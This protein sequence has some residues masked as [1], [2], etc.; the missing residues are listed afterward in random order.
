MTPARRCQVI[1]SA[2]VADEF[3]LLVDDARAA[4]R[5]PAFAAAARWI[6]EGLARTP[7][8]FGESW[9][10]RPGSERIFRRGFVRPVQLRYAV[11][12]GQRAVSIRRFTLLR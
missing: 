12:D 5:L 2:A 6:M 4:G 3:R 10:P 11:H 8:E 9:F 1:S 7:T